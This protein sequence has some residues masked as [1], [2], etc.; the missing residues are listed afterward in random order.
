MATKTKKS[1]AKAKPATAAETSE[2]IEEQTRAFLKSG[3]AIEKV[4]RG[5][6]GQT[7]VSGKRH[8]TIS[9]GKN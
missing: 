3:G 9:S 4:P 8:I 6:S 1:T 7:S 5:V 2:S